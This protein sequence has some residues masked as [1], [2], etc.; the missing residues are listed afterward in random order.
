MQPDMQD[1]TMTTTSSTIKLSIYNL[2]SPGSPAPLYQHYPGQTRPQP[3]YV[4]LTEEGQV[5]AFSSGEIG[6][7]V[8]IEVWNGRTTRWSV[9]PT[10]RAST[11]AELLQG[12]A[13]P[14]LQR[15][16]AGHEVAFDGSNHRGRLSPDADHASNQLETLFAALADDPSDLQPVWKVGDWLWTA[17]TLAQ[18]WD[19]QPLDEAVAAIESAAHAEGVMIDGDVRTELLQLAHELFLDGAAC[20]N[21]AQLSSTHLSTL[22]A[23]GKITQADIDAALSD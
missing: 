5:S 11:L 6:H 9:P 19:T 3:A 17:C 13:L 1:N 10:V 2:L 12:E 22:V 23:E 8:P 14:L 15:V 16:H 18:H 4:S 21:L 7:A 20:G